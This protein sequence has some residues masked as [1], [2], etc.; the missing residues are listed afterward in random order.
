MEKH[1]TKISLVRLRFLLIAVVLIEVPFLLYVERVRLI[2]QA[3]DLVFIS[4]ILHSVLTFVCLA[5]LVT[6]FMLRDHDIDKAPFLKRVPL[7][8]VFLILIIASVIA[9]FDQVTHGHVTIFTIYMLSFG[10]LIYVKPYHHLY[11]Y[12]VPFAIFVIGVVAFQ[13]DSDILRTHI[14]NGVIIFIAVLFASSVFYKY[15]AKDFIYNEMLTEKNKELE[16]LSTID[17]L[18]GLPNR[19]HFDKQVIYEASINRR[20]KHIASLLM[21]DIDHFK[22][23]NDSYGHDAGDFIL[24]ELAQVFRKS[25][26]ESDTVCRWGGEEFMFLLSHTEVD[27]AK[28]LAERLRKLV[29]ATAFAYHGTK[30]SITISIGIAELSNQKD[31]FE[32]SYKDAD[33]ALYEAKNAGRNCVKIYSPKEKA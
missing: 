7:H 27:G 18:T 32:A 15:A 31:G 22:A 4:Y 3:H 26:R 16:V 17:P 29:S 6:L 12:G 11:L 20:Y 8:A 28:V 19:R 1:L 14:I 9:L 13:E 23:L 21:V 33:V 5:L 24:K 10:L 2:E 30:L 25:V